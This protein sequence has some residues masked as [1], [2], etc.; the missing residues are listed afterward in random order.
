M[1]RD[2]LK[3]KDGFLRPAADEAVAAAA[4]AAVVPGGSGRG[5]G[6]GGGG[7]V[8]VGLAAAAVDAVSVAAVE[9]ADLLG[10]G[11]LPAAAAVD[12]PVALHRRG[13]GRC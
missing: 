8:V 13:Q 4:V 3:L 1:V 10:G 9:L 5:G 6:D 12:A 7:R 11:A 2:G